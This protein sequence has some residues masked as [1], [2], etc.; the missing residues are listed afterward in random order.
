MMSD[1]KL[2]QGASFDL[3]KFH[4]FVWLNGNVPFA[5]QRWE[6]LGDTSQVPAVAPTFAWSKQ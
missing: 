2:K 5:L 3:Q 1:A 4:D 6:M